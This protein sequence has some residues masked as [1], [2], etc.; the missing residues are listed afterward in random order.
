MSASYKSHRIGRFVLITALSIVIFMTF[1]SHDDS[2]IYISGEIDWRTYSDIIENPMA[3]NITVKS[4][5]GSTIVSTSLLVQLSKRKF[6][7]TVVDYCF[8]ACANSFA[9][10]AQRIVL[11]EDA[12]ILLHQSPKALASAIGRNGYRVGLTHQT[13]SALT[14]ALYE[15]IENKDLD[16]LVEKAMDRTEISRIDSSNC[17]PAMSPNLACV[18]MFVTSLGWVPSPEQLRSY[19]F[20]I[21]VENR[22][23]SW[24]VVNRTLVCKFGRIKPMN[25][26]YIDELKQIDPSIEC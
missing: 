8:S 20:E 2:D 9:F 17:A 12:F 16:S 21:E 4:N 3:R 26:Y 19:G 25:I 22:F 15:K 1:L 6:D 13:L 10:A 24:E 14:S 7:L 11:E 23:A 18:D 5:G